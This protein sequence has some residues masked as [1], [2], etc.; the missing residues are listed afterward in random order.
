MIAR[1]IS[2][3]LL[4]ALCGA[5]MIPLQVSLS[6][7]AV[8]SHFRKT[9]LDLDLRERIG[10]AGFLA[11]LSGFRSPLAA[12]LWIEAH[13][14]WE[15]TEWGRMAGLFDTVTTLQP[16]S[17]PYW[18]MAAWHMAWN[19]SVAALQNEKQSS[20][21]LRIRAQREYFR[22]GRDFLERGIR[23]NPDRYQLYLQLGVLLRDK[24][25]DHCGAAEAFKKASE[26]SEAPPYA[27]R[28]AGY[29]MAK[30][31]GREREAY[32]WLRRLWDQGERQRLPSLINV[33]REME[34]KLDIPAADRIGS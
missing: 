25:E 7:E 22:L 1:R 6:R 9:T 24:F 26:F 2:A 32:E 34:N 11:A 30:C 5:A 28:F 29:E 8:S 20:E 12:I 23:N 16:R 14:A 13:S 18:D 27:A 21:A 33:L 31:P 15:N 10:Q 19:A 4:L 3:I 17:I